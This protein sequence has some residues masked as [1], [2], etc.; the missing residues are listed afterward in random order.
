[1]PNA[2]FKINVTMHKQSLNIA[3]VCM[4]VRPFFMGVTFPVDIKQGKV[5]KSISAGHIKYAIRI[6]YMYE[7]NHPPWVY[8]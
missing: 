1:M 5:E 8:H 7:K 2:R 3:D 4:Q 6:I